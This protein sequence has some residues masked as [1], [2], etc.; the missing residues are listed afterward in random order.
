[1]DNLALLCNLYG[2]GPQTLRR[3]REAG[4]GTLAALETLES[5]RLASL[6]RTS[7][8]S[9]KR[10][11]SEGRLLRER[12]EPAPER[13]V[14]LAQDDAP[15]AA[16]PLVAGVLTVWRERDAQ[17]RSPAASAKPAPGAPPTPAV[18]SSAASS[19]SLA[20]LVGADGALFERLVR[21]GVGSPEALSEAD[22]LDL[23]GRGVGGYTHLLHLQ[24]LA[25]RAGASSAAGHAD[26]L[27]P[28]RPPERRGSSGSPAP[29]AAEPA[30]RFSPRSRPREA[31][32]TDLEAELVRFAAR[33]AEAPAV[34][35]DAAPVEDAGSSG[36]FA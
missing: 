11:Q 24:F 20:A 31:A 12:S 25:R 28:A 15:D 33:G 4:F 14:A 19:A 17:A 32:S 22:V 10:F 13:Q 36:P 18:R 1:M 34:G 3:L 23:A 9:A 8:R 5:E 29:P 16:D 35:R 2:D 27:V 21:A 26:V 30:L 6:L 7:V